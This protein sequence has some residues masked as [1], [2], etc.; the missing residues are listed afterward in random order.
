MTYREAL[1]QQMEAYYQITTGYRTATM[2]ATR[3]ARKPGLF[4]KQDY[5]PYVQQFTKLAKDGETLNRKQLENL[6]ETEEEKRIAEL[7]SRNVISFILLCEENARFYE[8]SDKK[9]YRKNGVTLQ[10]YAECANRLQGILDGTVKELEKLEQAY[11]EYFSDRFTD[12]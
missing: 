2:D 9:Q 11:K 10:E 3:L 4:K 12:E 8:L 1:Q 6:A 5:S 7:F